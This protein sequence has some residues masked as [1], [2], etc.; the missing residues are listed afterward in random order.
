M[1]TIKITIFPQDYVYLATRRESSA[2]TTNKAKYKKFGTYLN[3]Y[4]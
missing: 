2:V 1:T 4:D 3:K